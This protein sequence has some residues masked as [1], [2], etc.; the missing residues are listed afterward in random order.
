MWQ[1]R[2]VR[3]RVWVQNWQMQCCGAPFSVGSTVEWALDPVADRAGL[4]ELLGAEEASRIT[5]YEERHDLPPTAYRSVGTVRA[6]SAAFCRR[7]ATTDDPELLVPVP[8]ST[9]IEERTSADGW[10]A[11]H[12][13]LYFE[14]YIVDL[15]LLSDRDAGGEAAPGPAEAKVHDPRSP[16]PR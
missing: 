7:A 12:G 8:G 3:R 4:T 16:W 11:E 1:H 5:H 2:S 15:D 13:D 6:I 10:E 14:G 9:L